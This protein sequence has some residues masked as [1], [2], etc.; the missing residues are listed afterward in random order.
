MSSMSSMRRSM[1]SMRSMSS[2]SSIDVRIKKVMLFLCCS[3]YSMLRRRLV[4]G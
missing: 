2:M 1:R 4:A 3:S